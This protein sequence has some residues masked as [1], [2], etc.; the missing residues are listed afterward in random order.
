MQKYKDFIRSLKPFP[1]NK[2]FGVSSREKLI[3]Y[4]MYY[5]ENNGIPIYFNYVCV[6]AFKMFPKREIIYCN[7]NGNW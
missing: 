5:L 2:Y 1:E 3:A 7:K 4:T 6:A